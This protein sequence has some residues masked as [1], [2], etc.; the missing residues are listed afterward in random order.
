[1]CERRERQSRIFSTVASA[2]SQL[3]EAK[4]TFT[5]AT[6]REAILTEEG[7]RF[8]LPEIGSAVSRMFSAGQMGPGYSCTCIFKPNGNKSFK[9]YSFRKALYEENNSLFEQYG[10][11]ANSV[12]VPDLEEDTEDGSD[13]PEAVV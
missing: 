4:D 5:A 8:S 11:V 10:S 2:V 1:M 3:T 6:V 7:N 9:L 12:S 13:T